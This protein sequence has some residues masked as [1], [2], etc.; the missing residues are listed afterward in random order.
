LKERPNNI[1]HYVFLLSWAEGIKELN[2]QFFFSLQRLEFSVRHPVH[3][4]LEYKYDL[5]NTK[6]SVG[7][8]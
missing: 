3:I 6:W 2:S 4:R 5:I 7:M 8:F 1:F